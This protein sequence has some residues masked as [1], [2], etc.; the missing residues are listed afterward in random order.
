M[1]AV[2]IDSTNTRHEGTWVNSP[3]T[4]ITGQ[5]WIGAPTGSLIFDGWFADFLY[6]VGASIYTTT[7]PPGLW[8][9]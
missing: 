7:K 9:V 8:P 1:A 3:V 5:P 6:V 2:I 4:T